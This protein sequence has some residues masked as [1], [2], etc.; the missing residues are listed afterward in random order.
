MIILSQVMIQ[1]LAMSQAADPH[2]QVVIL[3]ACYIQ[4]QSKL[5]DGTSQNR[6]GVLDQIEQEG[7]DGV[8]KCL[9]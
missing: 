5:I 7:L 9:Q 3:T 1:A 4:Q 6:S 2:R 8:S